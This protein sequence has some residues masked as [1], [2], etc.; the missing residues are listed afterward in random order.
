M[1]D[2]AGALAL[3]FYSF[4]GQKTEAGEASTCASSI[5][6]WYYDM[7]TVRNT[8][9]DWKRIRKPQETRTAG[10]RIIFKNSEPV[11]RRRLPRSFPAGARRTFRGRRSILPPLRQFWALCQNYLCSRR[12]R[13]GSCSGACTIFDMDT[14]TLIGCKYLKA[15]S[16]I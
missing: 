2:L 4:T 9:K 14:S 7:T 15:N 1:L 8:H 5:R 13:M 11:Q 6:Y 16:F 10:T 12:N 3:D